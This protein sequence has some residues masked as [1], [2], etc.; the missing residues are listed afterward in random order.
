[1][2]QASYSPL[3]LFKFF[4]FWTIHHKF[5]TI[6]EKS[7]IKPMNGVPMVLLHKKLKR[8]KQCLREFNKKDFADISLKVKAKRE[9]LVV[10]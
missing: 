3:K 8:L 2:D 5:Q 4:N 6:V 10:V 7:W 9:E 1:M